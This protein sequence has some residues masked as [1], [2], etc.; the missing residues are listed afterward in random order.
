MHRLLLFFML[1]LLSACVSK[2]YQAPMDENVYASTREI[3]R[4]ILTYADPLKRDHVY[5]NHSYAYYE[6]EEGRFLIWMDFHSQKLLDVDQSRRLLVEMVEGFLESLNNH[7]I[8]YGYLN[9]YP[10]AFPFTYHDLYIS[11]EL[12]SYHGVYVDPLYVGRF[13]LADGY[14]SSFYA[15]TALDPRSCVFHQH[16]EPYE[17]SLLFVTVE[18]ELDQERKYNQAPPPAFGEP[19]SYHEDSFFDI[20]VQKGSLNEHPIQPGG[21]QPLSGEYALPGGESQPLR[22]NG[23]VQ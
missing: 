19:Q 14:M 6:P 20:P 7:P 4:V 13:E 21:N 8:L 16:F 15:H 23:W 12:E 9:E 11:V 22:N 3:S 2:I 10:N 1:T 17:S 18:K 5:L